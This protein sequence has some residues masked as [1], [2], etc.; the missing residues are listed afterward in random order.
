MKRFAW[1]GAAFLVGATL[2][3]PATS[4]ALCYAL[5]T[6][7]STKL[8]VLPIAAYLYW[9]DHGASSLVVWWLPLCAAGAG[10]LTMLPAFTILCWPESRRLRLARSGEN[11]PA[12]R[13]AFSD[14]HGSAEWI[15]MQEAQQ[16]FP[17]PHPAYGGVVVGEAYRVDQDK[18]ASGRFDP[19]LQATWGKGGTMPLLI[20][21]C[22]SD[23]T[24]GAVFAGS[25]GYKT[26]AV[27]VPTLACWTGSAVVLDPSGQVGPMTKQ[28]RMAVVTQIIKETGGAA[29]SA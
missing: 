13:R 1:A 2:W 17:G 29:V 22:T 10:V 6:L 24:H 23:A 16:L 20:D 8:T 5:G 3:L 27:T 4:V 14:A 28:L 25:G 9:R 18:A 12:P 15:G 11:V 7:P 19:D 21:P 26:T